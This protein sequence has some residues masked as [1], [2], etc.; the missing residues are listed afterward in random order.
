[1]ASSETILYPELFSAWKEELLS[2]NLTPL[3]LNFIKSYL[4]GLNEIFYSNSN[5]VHNLVM[6]RAKFLIQ[7][8]VEI[9]KQK[10]LSMIMN[11]EPVESSYL[12]KQELLF[13]DYINN[14]D[15]V[16]QNKNL[17]FSAQLLDF[18]LDK[19]N[20]SMNKEK[21]STE[22]ANKENLNFESRKKDKIEVIFLKDVEEFIYKN[23]KRFGPF[24]KNDEALIPEEIYRKVLHPKNIAMEK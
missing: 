5:P 10:I 17:T 23:N 20:L 2:K 19:S 7:N 4:Q 6:K 8:L 3:N 24:K 16:L 12:S 14:S 11:K 18:I 15:N 9:R 21:I 1:M 22:L 13:Y